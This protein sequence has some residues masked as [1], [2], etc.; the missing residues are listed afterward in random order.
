M[1]FNIQRPGRFAVP[2][3]VKF[4]AR[5]QAQPSPLGQSFRSNARTEKP[6]TR[7]FLAVS[8]DGEE[9]DWRGRG[10]AFGFFRADVRRRLRCDFFRP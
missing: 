4:H 6:K 3:E 7:P 10:L 5:S 8:K 9:I 1:T 2:H